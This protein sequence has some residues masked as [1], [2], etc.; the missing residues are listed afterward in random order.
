MKLMTRGRVACAV[1]SWIAAALAPLIIAPAALAQSQP[2]AN[3]GSDMV[4]VDSDGQ[5]G[6]T[7]MLDGRGSH[8]PDGDIALYRWD[9][10]P[11]GS[12]AQ[13]L[14]TGETLQVFLPDGVHDISLTVA[15]IETRVSF[16]TV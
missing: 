6:E 5:P 2:I 4:A 1:L 10:R 8:D 13:T 3:A 11:P 15:D 7:V 9:L 12:P 14:G 16:D